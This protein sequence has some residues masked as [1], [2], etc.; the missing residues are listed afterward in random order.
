MFVSS[1]V[2]MLATTTVIWC[3]S[4]IC[5]T[6]A[7]DV[8]EIHRRSEGAWT[9]SHL[10][11]LYND[12]ITN[13]DP[14]IDSE[15][16]EIRCPCQDQVPTMIH[17]RTEKCSLNEPLRITHHTMQFKCRIGSASQ[18]YDRL[19]LSTKNSIRFFNTV[20]LEAFDELI[21]GLKD[22]KLS[23]QLRR[24]KDPADF[25]SDIQ[26]RNQ[27]LWEGLASTVNRFQNTIEDICRL[28]ARQ[29]P[30]LNRFLVDIR[31]GNDTTEE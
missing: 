11:C 9:I 26:E 7:E 3:L 10:A 31:K 21:H 2:N 28:D 19:G 12:T 6:T 20:P 24:S 4:V 13:C 5:L 29:I 17:E 8:I 27:A 1:M 16:L 18:A 15:T 14:E 30:N 23:H 22:I 25:L